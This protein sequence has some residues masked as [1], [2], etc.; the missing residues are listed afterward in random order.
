[1]AHVD[2]LHCSKTL[3]TFVF[4]K[5]PIVKFYHSKAASEGLRQLMLTSLLVVLKAIQI[6]RYLL[7]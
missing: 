1:M 3:Y 5:L 2:C 7:T 6:H 4:P